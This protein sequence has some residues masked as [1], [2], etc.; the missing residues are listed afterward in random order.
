M[1]GTFGTTAPFLGIAKFGYSTHPYEIMVDLL[2]NEIQL[3][4]KQQT[5]NH[6]KFNEKIVHANPNP[7]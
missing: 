2:E 3:P 7:K 5:P 4:K 1:P 6:L